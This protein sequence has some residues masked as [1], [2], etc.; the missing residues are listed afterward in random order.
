[1]PF[2][3]QFDPRSYSKDAK[4][5][6]ESRTNKLYLKTIQRENEKFTNELVT[7]E[8]WTSDDVK[9]LHSSCLL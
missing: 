5:Y 7:Y 4:I 9:N 6:E 2:Q 3:K 8:E 1:M